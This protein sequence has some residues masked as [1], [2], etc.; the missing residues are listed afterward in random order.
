[1]ARVYAGNL[2]QPRHKA[3]SAIM[4]QMRTIAHRVCPALSKTAIGYASKIEM[5]KA[6]TE[7]LAAALI[8]YGQPVKLHV[9]LDGCPADYK[10]LFDKSFRDAKNVEVD[11]S[12]TPSIGN[13]ATFGKQVDLLLEEEEAR[14]LYFSEDDY[15]YKPCAF[16]AM[17]EMLDKNGAD[18]V[19]PLDHPDRYRGITFENETSPIVPATFCHWRQVPSTCLTFMTTHDVLRR[20]RWVFDAHTRGTMDSSMWLAATKQKLFAPR[21]LIGPG[22]RYLCGQNVPYPRLAQLC[23]WKWF[24][25]KLFTTRKHTLWSPIPSLAIHLSSDC[26]PPC[27]S[28]DKDWQV[29]GSHS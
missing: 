24:G 8:H 16:S 5:V 12:E 20:T 13:N 26:I 25:V 28:L 21:A 23:A 4:K 7:S 29:K 19:T 9:I 27:T 17:A 2:G 18:F 3:E 14:L 22:L 11:I 10:A 1:M 6:T 15:L